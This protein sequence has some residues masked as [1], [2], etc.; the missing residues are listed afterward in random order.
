M[1]QGITIKFRDGAIVSRWWRWAVWGLV[2]W[3]GA[4]ALQAA[5][6]VILATE[7]VDLRIRY[8]PEATPMLDIV[9][10]NDDARPPMDHPATNTVL[11]AA[12]LARLELPV[13]LPPLG[14]AGEPIWVLPASQREGLLYLGMSAEGNPFGVFDGPLE[15][16][17]LAVDGPGHF[18]LWQAELGGLRFWMNSRDGLGEEDV[19]RQLVGGHSHFDWGFTTSG[20]YRLTFQ[21]VARR[22]GEATNLL[23][24]P[25]EFTFHILPLPPVTASPFEQWQASQ[26]PGESNPAVVGEEADPDGDRLVNL[27]EYA[28]G[29]SPKAADA[30]P[31]PGPSIRLEG[32]AGQL[33]AVIRVPRAASA[34]DVEYRTESASSL[35][36]PW[37]ELS[38][39]SETIPGTGDT[40]VV[41]FRD[42]EPVGQLS[43]VFYRVKAQRTNQP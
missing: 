9:A 6:P 10:T 29:R 26:W 5:D 8:R 22:L 2:V 21:A 23:S 24:A 11:Q 42:P 17:L 39:A 4:V 14:S 43:Q 19:F 41:T 33:R 20:V 36:G 15:M 38:L 13:D 28:L 18:F 35:A 37:R 12:E 32:D 34:T 16:R 1:S 7:H 31:L 27:W 30:D 40:V 25:T 3:F